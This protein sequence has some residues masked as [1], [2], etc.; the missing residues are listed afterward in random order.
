MTGP[1]YI[2]VDV[3]TG[4]ARAA[5]VTTTGDIL[6]SSTQEINMWEPMPGF[7]EQS[8]SNIWNACVKVIKVYV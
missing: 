8:S 6:F 3:G 5:L 2:G 7:F 1:Y 4:S